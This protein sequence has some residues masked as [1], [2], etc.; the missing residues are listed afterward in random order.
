MNAEKISLKNIGWEIEDDTLIVTSE[1]TLTVLSTS[2]LGGGYSQTRCIIN[3]HV[4]K[5][6]CHDSPELFL[7]KVACRLGLDP[8]ATVGLMTAA[9]LDNLAVKN[10]CSKDHQVCAVVTGGVSNAAA[11]GETA[12]ASDYGAGT[13]NIIL[14]IGGVHKESA[15]A[16]CIIT[17]TEAK[18]AAL[19][20]L[21]VKGQGGDLPATGTTTD[22]V[23]VAATAQGRAY[24]FSGT[25]TVLGG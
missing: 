25:G 12:A 1:R 5:E 9:D 4:E 15:M 16:G 23:V 8:E 13:I 19:L 10:E 22:T 6:F 20:E 17:A 14:L 24:E 7:K 21:G 3:H 2:V 18:T 11:A